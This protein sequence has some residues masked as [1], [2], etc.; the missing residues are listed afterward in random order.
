MN[1]TAIKAL[2]HSLKRDYDNFSKLGRIAVVLSVVALLVIAALS[3]SLILV[4]TEERFTEFYVLNDQGK[5]H[6][7]TQNYTV[8]HEGQVI[9]GLNNHQG[10]NVDYTVEVWQVNYT[11]SDMQVKVYQ[12]YTI[13]VEKVTLQDQK[14]NLN[15]PWFIQY[16]HTMPLNFTKSGNY[17]LFFMLYIDE[18]QSPTYF[19]GA[20]YATDPIVSWKVVECVNNQL[21]FLKLNV[22]VIL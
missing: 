8:G 14:I 17:S 21:Q 7:Y 1:R 10:R 19:A 15:D 4:D 9:F 16:Q 6:T 3:V 13:G 5:A 2:L 11:F 12:M 22:S 20:N 18:K